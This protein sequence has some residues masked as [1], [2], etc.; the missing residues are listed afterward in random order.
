MRKRGT[1]YT[2]APP[3]DAL[4][5]KGI[6]P[7]PFSQQAH[8]QLLVHNPALLQEINQKKAHL[9]KLVSAQQQIQ[10]RREELGRQYQ[11]RQAFILARQSASPTAPTHSFSQQ[12]L[13]QWDQE[14]GLSKNPFDNLMRTIQAAAG[15]ALDVN[16]VLD[17]HQVHMKVL[18]KL[19]KLRE[20]QEKVA[21]EINRLE[22]LSQQQDQ[23]ISALHLELH[24]S[25]QTL[26]TPP[27]SVAKRVSPLPLA[28]PPILLKRF[29]RQSPLNLLRDTSRPATFPDSSLRKACD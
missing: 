27:R 28:L 18:K 3:K 12:A 20:E 10:A 17:K 29:L 8:W 1:R 22:R 5:Q 23:Q 24:T 19:E 7:L 15:M 26:N 25:I 13:D 14:K 11:Q 6:S 16:G 4:F 9:E 21:V 2:E